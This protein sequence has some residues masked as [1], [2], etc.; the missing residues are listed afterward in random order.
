MT[1]IYKYQLK[2]NRTELNMPMGAQVLTVQVQHGEVY[3]WAKVDETLKNECRVFD[4]YG[5]G[6]AVSNDPRLLYVATFLMDGG[7]LVWHVFEST[8]IA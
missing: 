1:T 4:I 7:D 2:P 8:Y 3:L 6:H 5:T